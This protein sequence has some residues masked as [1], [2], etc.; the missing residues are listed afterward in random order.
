MTV[1]NSQHSVIL[2]NVYKL[3][4]KKVDKSQAELVEQFAKI[5]FKNV[6]R[7]DLESRVDSDMYGAT[8][9][10]WN[11]F[12]HYDG[13]A[14]FI[15]V[16]NPEVG[17]H[18]WQSSHT[19]IEI[20]TK[21]MPFLVDSVR[22]AINRMSITAHLL[23]HSPIAIQRD[24][25]HKL[26]AFYDSKDKD[27]QDKQKQTV[28]LIEIDRQTSKQALAQIEKELHSV[29]D[30][31]SLAVSDW[32]PMMQRL[33]DIIANYDKK[34]CPMDDHSCGQVHS[35]LRWIR[36]HNFTLMGYRH[37]QAKAI[38]GDHRWIADNDSSLGL[39]KNS[40]SNRE[41][42]LSRL[43]LSARQETLSQHPLI[44][45]K[46]NSKSRV[47]R[48]AY[49]DYIG[50]KEFDEKGNVVGEH[51]FIGLYSAAFYN[52][53]ALEVP[54]IK[55][56]I[57]NLIEQSGFEKTTH[58]YKAFLNILE[59][60]P[61]DELLQATEAELGKI[62]LGILQMQERG[63]S[64]MFVR[65]D[66]FG[67]F[68]S[69][70]VYVPRERYN[71][72]LR[73]ETQELLKKSFGSEQDVEFTTF[74]SESVYARTHYM[75]RVKNN[76]VEI[77]VKDIEKNIIELTKSW[78]DKLS[79]SL[80]A[81]HGE[82]KGKKLD[83]KY[84]NAF[85][86][87]Y[88]DNNLPTMAVVDIEK[89]ESLD[90][91][92]TLDML[93]YRPQ[94]EAADSPMV[95]LKLFHRN[96]PIHLSDVLPMLEHFGLRVIDESPFQVKTSDGSVNWIMDF[97]MLHATSNRMSLEQAQELFQNAFSKV[98]YKQLEDDS[99]N[100][101]VLGAGM[102][103][104]KVTILRAY[105]KYMRQ[106]GSSFS[107]DYIARTLDNYP[108]IAILLVQLFEQRF[109]P[110]I[111]RSEKKEETLLAAVKESLDKVSNLDD[112]RII[113]RYVDLI[114]ATLRTNFYQL[115][116]QGN[117]KSYISFKVLPELIPEMPLPLPKF[118]IFVYSP[119]IEGVHLRGGKVARGGLRWS[120]RQEDF[121]TEVLGLVKAQQ[122]KN[123][124]IV[125][126]GAKG[127]FVCKDL[128]TQGGRAAILKEGQECYRIFIR[129]LLDITDNI[130]QGEIVPPVD[131]VRLDEDDP[132]LVVAADK[133]TATFSDIANGISAEYNFWLG[134]AFASG[135][136][137]GYDH[138]G[139]GITARGGWE[140][141]KRHFREMGID[142]QTTDFTCVGIGDMAGDV[143][144]NGM[145]LSEHTRLV[146]AFNH[147]HI[148]FDPDP[149]AAS[150][151][152]ERLRL[153]KDPSL[154]WAD[155]NKDLIS[156]GGG[157]FSR[158]EKAI[159]LTPEMKKWL[160]TK[161][162][163]M[164]PS[165]L[166]KNI[167]KMPVDLLWNGGIGTYVKS[168][169]ESHSDVGDRANDDLRVNGRDLTAKI[170]GEGGNLGCTQLGRVEFAANGGRVNTD[171]IDNV[172]GVDCSDNEVNIKI[173][174]NTLVQN[175]E[176][177]LKQRNQML[178]E[179]TDDV[180]QIVIKDCYRQTQSIS[181]SEMG[182]GSRLKEQI[183]FIHGLEREG[184][185]NRELE[186]I[187][188]D[189]E[190]SERQA[191]DRGLTRPELAVLLA[192]GKMVLKEKL[193]IPEVT[194]NPYHAKLLVSAFPKMLQD[195]FKE[196]MKQH[197]LK[198]E[199]I[200][201][202][203]TNNMLND[204]G[205]NFVH[206]LQEETGASISEV[207][208]A[209]S[210]VKGIF[211]MD[212]LWREIEQLD[213]KI[214]ADVQLKMLDDMR[215]TLRRS[216]RWYLRHG[217]K[218]MDI[219]EAIGFYQA[220]KDDLSKN[221]EHY[222]VDS[223]YSE[224]NEKTQALVKAGVPDAVAFKVASL[225]NMFSCL[226]LAQVCTNEDKSVSLVASLYY[227]L[228][229]RL[230]LHWFLDQI[231]RQ[232]VANHWQALARASYR[233]ELDWQQRSLTSVLLKFDPAAADAEALLDKWVETHQ[234]LL[235]RWN[236]MMSEF[237]TSGSHE[238]AKF[239]VALRELMLLSLNCSTAS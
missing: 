30:E 102:T 117:D 199:I 141:V 144:G 64:R 206:R 100:R 121:R 5:L 12:H 138:K 218:S 112:D 77:N 210:V 127:G 183:R 32:Q 185:L 70:M 104:R 229:N 103:G 42:L 179:M 58:A 120:D 180:A 107:K 63:I 160:G 149:D 98:W 91:N 119:R 170:I 24:K 197:P 136:S 84:D 200:A 14:P 65:K 158:S 57:N 134:D 181:I 176:L 118:E 85:T 17:K 99:F 192:Y 62:V 195:K 230:Q 4:H 191:H 151:Y 228:G 29:L 239:S 236:H 172:G 67:R 131:V 71:T 225:S 212:S 193:N 165:E 39:M 237:K 53:S 113:R 86:H 69:C 27:N 167:L 164:T 235:E 226:D 220:T 33:D 81:S 56:K 162:L 21:D 73:K 111:K 23:I 1:A 159:K 146:A 40:V 175:G 10:L 22:M 168:A 114:M 75:V 173:L 123:T 215:R 126:V 82:A 92:H 7:E 26:E 194:D 36:N 76:N 139:M 61:R 216:A 150:S 19:I 196:Q 50:I 155:Y 9:S 97:S 201:T 187:P 49:M 109:D 6:S 213:N 152:Q 133:G 142:C 108:D 105:A 38:E 227:K 221:L 204:M 116:A 217:V 44:L 83:Q 223:E 87:S 163:T 128:P 48:P 166:I 203:L 78:N 161:Q 214:G 232:E 101:L 188:S 110:K 209:Y 89:L 219:E 55:D 184:R 66:V 115:D 47:H 189:D 106:T 8:L 68:Y 143:F 11:E 238:F 222:L 198:G 93:F 96:Q 186:F 157:I 18:G 145:L 132:Y 202:K 72:Q 224:L 140:S 15:R 79:A 94:E 52:A 130:V 54:V 95:K 80:K 234:L 25:A 208:N 154:N 60:Y 124:V 43:P 34:P 122:V 156:K 233:E 125:P 231:N 174:L 31:V 88:K 28:F 59:T 137:V 178:Y 182:S 207:V 46:T 13:K 171:F 74:F 45:T 3:I 16:F 148:F 211:N 135:G 37:Y 90:E 205:M 147:M 35:F 41:R 177:T 51:R 153:F 169:K 190:M 129:A 20:I 2:E